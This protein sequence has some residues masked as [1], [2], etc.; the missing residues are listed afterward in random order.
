M[1][2]LKVGFR[3]VTKYRDRG[4]GSMAAINLHFVPQATRTRKSPK[5]VALF[6][7][8]LGYTTHGNRKRLAQAF[9]EIFEATKNLEQPRQKT[10]YTADEAL[11]F[12]YQ[13]TRYPALPRR[14][15]VHPRQTLDRF[16][17][18]MLTSTETR[19]RDQVSYRWAANGRGQSRK[20]SH[21]PIIMVDQ[22]WLWMLEDGTLITCRHEP[23]SSESRYWAR[24]SDEFHRSVLSRS[25]DLLTGSETKVTTQALS[26]SV[27]SEVIDFGEQWGPMDFRFQDGFRASIN[28][29]VE[30][31]SGLFRRFT[32]ATKLSHE[33]RGK[34]VKEN[35]DDFLNRSDLETNLLVELMD[36]KD[37]LNTIRTV[38]TQQRTVLEE[39]HRI[40]QGSPFKKDGDAHCLLDEQLDGEEEKS[41]NLGLMRK[42][43]EVLE[44]N[45][46]VV[47]SLLADA[48]KVQRSVESLLTFKQ[49]HASTMEA[50]MRRKREETAERSENTLK[51]FGL[52]SLLFLPLSFASSLFALDVDVYPKDEAGE[53]AWPIR[54][55]MGLIFGISAAI[56]LVLVTSSVFINEILAFSHHWRRKLLAPTPAATTPPGPAKAT[57]PAC[58]SDS[59]SE[60]E[61]ETYEDSEGSERCVSS[62][63]VYLSDDTFSSSSSDAEDEQGGAAAG[64][65]AQPPPPP[66]F[67]SAVDRLMG[68]GRQEAAGGDLEKGS[69]VEVGAAAG[70]RTSGEKAQGSKERISG[71]KA[72]VPYQP[73]L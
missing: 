56:L 22:L 47:E 45:V 61:S 2:K 66:L 26:H 64:P 62:D 69:V 34:S 18:S 23:P 50:R 10:N 58:D 13:L 73:L 38:Q 54:Q 55:V 35:D 51:A 17:Y 44:K 21:R 43:F 33:T 7:P 41:R 40:Y 28:R 70:S 71:A 39:L 49:M 65:S 19:D 24:S 30:L 48:E 67:M 37:E 60:P 3:D 68:R 29:I 32:A 6:M 1:R 59:D 25:L 11:L 46:A 31:E 16:G 9:R 53:T 52:I 36:I 14:R 20:H 63:H 27:L 42:T 5:L 15:Q 57:I 12:G 8:V 4:V 72:Y